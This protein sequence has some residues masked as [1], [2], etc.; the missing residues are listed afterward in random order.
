MTKVPLLEPEVHEMGLEAVPPK[1]AEAL[2]RE[3]RRRDD[4]D[5]PQL[6][7]VLSWS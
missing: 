7:L 2:F 6:L 4:V 3:A 1:E 5:G